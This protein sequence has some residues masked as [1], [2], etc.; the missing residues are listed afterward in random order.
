MSKTAAI[1]YTKDGY[2]TR[3]DRLLG[4][5]SAGEG[6]LKSW[7]KYGT[8]ESLHCYTRTEAEFQDFCQL[9]TPWLTQPRKV[10]WINEEQ[11]WLIADAGVLYRPDPVL[12]QLIWQRRFINQ[13][14]YS[15]CGVTHTIATKAVMESIG[16]L[17]IAPSQP[18]DALICTSVAVRKS[19]EYLFGVWGE[20]LT[21]RMGGQPQP[22]IQLPVIPLGVDQQGFPQGNDAIASRQRLRQSLGIADNDIVV[23][24]VGRLCFSAK[25]HPVPMYM[26][27]EKAAQTTKQ[28]I[29]LIQAG[30]FDDPREEPEF[31]NSG[32]IFAPSVNHIF[33]DGRLP[34]IRVNIWSASDIFISLS[35]NIQET[36]GLTPIEAMANGLPVVVSDWDG[37]K[38]SVRDQIDGFRIPTL[39]PAPDSCVDITWDYMNDKIN[40]PTYIGLTSLTIAIDVDICA[41]ALSQLINNEELRRKMGENGRKRVQEVYDWQVVIKAYEN[42]WQELGEI[43]EKAQESVPLKPGQPAY[44]LCDTPF[45]MFNHYTTNT[46]SLEMKLSLGSMAKP[47]TLDMI[48]RFWITSVGKDRRL[49]AD[50]QTEIFATIQQA[51]VITVGELI[52]RYT[53]TPVEIAYLQRTLLHWIK[54][55]IL[56]YQ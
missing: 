54:F 3:G 10:K 23:L 17:L 31:K 11:P 56:V 4:R 21:E 18:W 5:H 45:R 32:N 2:N 19:I 28:K 24:F 22:L 8:A 39:I 38:E 13:R 29:H 15:L 47:D 9:I 42:L 30:W 53:K 44:P 36:F 1:L 16:N 34:D 52:T 41:Q 12:S 50:L 7:V 37:Y 25:A 27:L 20:Y 33:L 51:G 55:N 35:D 43:R 26:A 48:Q 46:L 6:F 49:A 40:W 14:A